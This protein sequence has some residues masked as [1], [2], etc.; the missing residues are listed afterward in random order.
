MLT[1]LFQSEKEKYVLSAVETSFLE[2]ILLERNV[3]GVFLS[4]A[5]LL[6]IPAV[7]HDPP[8]TLR[9]CKWAPLQSVPNV[10]SSRSLCS[11]SPHIA[12]P[13]NPSLEK[14]RDR[15]PRGVME[16]NYSIKL[17]H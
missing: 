1:F 5:M 9:C 4:C 10:L 2:L 13:S 8:A 14:I 3:S 17:L 11:N 16:A 6:D 7:G 15:Q 12:A